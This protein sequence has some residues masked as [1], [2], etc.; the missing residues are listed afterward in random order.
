MTSIERFCS[1]KPTCHFLITCMRRELDRW[2]RY[3]F[4]I[5][6]LK[7][8]NLIDIILLSD[9]DIFPNIR[10]LILIG[11]TNPNGTCEAERSFSALRR[12]KKY[13]RSTMTE[14]RLAGLTMMAV[15]YAECAQ[16]NSEEIV[17][18]FSQA[19]PRHMFCSSILF[20]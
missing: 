18:R 9:Q 8:K 19:N 2:R 17:G 7:G 4:D 3:C 11:C 5:K 15:H 16:I 12:V 14:E 13:L 20:D 1:G 6:Q 10:Q